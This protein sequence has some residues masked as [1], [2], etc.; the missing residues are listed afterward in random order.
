VST[1]LIAA[2]TAIFL[3]IAVAFLIAIAIDIRAERERQSRQRGREIERFG[4]LDDADTFNR[5]V[6]AGGVDLWTAVILAPEPMSSRLVTARDAY[7]ETDRAAW[8][9]DQIGRRS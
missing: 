2:A 5:L 3:G 9:A 8:L 1:N 6:A 7:L 4:D